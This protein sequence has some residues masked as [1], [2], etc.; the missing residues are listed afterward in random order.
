MSAWRAG[1]LSLLQTAWPWLNGPADPGEAPMS[2]SAGSAQTESPTKPVADRIPGRPPR[3]ASADQAVHRLADNVQ[4]SVALQRDI[5]TRDSQVPM[6]PGWPKLRLTAPARGDAVGTEQV[7]NN[8]A[9]IVAGAPPRSAGTPAGRIVR[10]SDGY[11]HRP[12]GPGRR[13]AGAAERPRSGGHTSA[14]E[15]SHIHEFRTLVRR[16]HRRL[17][18]EPTA[19]PAGGRM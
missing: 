14:G 9:D 7:W 4:E 13:A 3:A 1:G 12:A 5:I 18:T 6:V 11:W 2:S 10:V 8:E 19:G 16:G 15:F 17:M